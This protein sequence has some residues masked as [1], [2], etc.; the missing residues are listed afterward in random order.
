MLHKPIF[1]VVT[2]LPAALALTLAGCSGPQTT[3]ANGPRPCARHGSAFDRPCV[4]SSASAPPSAMKP[5]GVA[6][7][8]LV[9]KPPAVQATELAAMKAMGMTSIRLDA[10]WGGVQY[11][12]RTSF[13]W[14]ALDQVVASVRAAGMTVD[15]II[16]GCPAWAAKAGTSGDVSPPPA[17]PAAFATFAAAVAARYAP[18]GVTMFE[19]WNEPNSALFWSPKPD[20]AAYTA[21]LRAAYASIKKADRSAF[22]VSGGLAPEVNDGRN[23]NAITFLQD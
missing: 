18:Q 11:A 19:I 7:P 1:L 4:T 13:S 14:T 5:M 10:D 8:D 21:D 17:S 22:V 9:A 16:D 12:G 3:N 6:E 23:I 20:P 2:A 15:L